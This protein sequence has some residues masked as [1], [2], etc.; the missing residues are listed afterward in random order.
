[1]RQFIDQDQRWAAGQ[2]CIE[3]KFV[4]GG[5]TIR[6]GTTWQHLEPLQQGFGLGPA[7]GIHP[8]HHNVDALVVPLM[9]R[10]EHGIR[11]A[12]PGC[13]AK[14]D[15]EFTTGLLGLF[16]LDTGE[17]SVG[18]GSLIVHRRMYLNVRFYGAMPERHGAR[19]EGDNVPCSSARRMMQVCSGSP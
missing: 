13:G 18:V 5:A 2:R 10:F 4:Q 7:V 6:H 17:Q 14:E 19:A 15:L 1:M 12:D 11:F 16:L 3:V 8:A 9:G